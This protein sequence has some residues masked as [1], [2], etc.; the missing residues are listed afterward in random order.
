MTDFEALL[1]DLGEPIAR[2]ELNRPERL[3]ALSPRA[4]EE[5]VRAA[6][7]IA[8]GDGVKVVIV[9]GAGR[10]FSAGFDLDA[11][12]G[13]P[14]RDRIDL[15]WRMADAVSAIPAV[16]IASIHGHCVG[17]GLVLAAACDIR[18]SAAGTRV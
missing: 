8:S 7:L 14:D 16:T 15:G 1:L 18:L 5:V 10:A 11:A 9:T 3:N 4:L 6:E 2:L 12:G 17:G 13:E